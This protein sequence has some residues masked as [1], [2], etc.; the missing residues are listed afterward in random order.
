MWFHPLF[1][2]RQ[3]LKYP[4]DPLYFLLQICY[5]RCKAEVTHMTTKKLYALSKIVNYQLFPSSSCLRSLI[6][7]H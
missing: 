4:S 3:V 6:L 1:Q 5:I 2:K 7:L